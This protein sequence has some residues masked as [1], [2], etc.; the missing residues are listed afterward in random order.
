VRI[1]ITAAERAG[2]GRDMTRT[3]SFLIVLAL[4]LTACGSGK[5]AA[6]RAALQK[7]ADIGA[8]EQIEVTWHKASSTHDVNL[9]MTIWADHA[10]ATL[11]GET[12][13][14]K[15]QIRDF[16]ANK[17]A[18]FRPENH[19][20]SETPAYKIRV[21]V[22]GDKGTLY[23]ECHYVDVNTKQVVAVVSAD[24]DVAR[25]N[26]KWLITKLVSATP[27]LSAY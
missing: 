9:M 15:A 11:G 5:E 17:A 21:T 23:F 7:E 3:L 13:S 25:I 2:R 20:V 18:P 24:Q 16:F 12:Y 1:P 8:I 19:W 27:T 4:A 26:G 14:G 10:T 22:D 6:S